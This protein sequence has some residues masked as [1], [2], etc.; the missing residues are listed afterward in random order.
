MGIM[1]KLRESKTIIFALEL[2]E[3]IE[4][5]IK[6]QEEKGWIIETV[7]HEDDKNFSFTRCTAKFYKLDRPEIPYL[8][9]TSPQE[10]IEAKLIAEKWKEICTELRKLTKEL[11]EAVKNIKNK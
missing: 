11:R 4:N 3:T 2:G 10:E 9:A 8:I 1:R 7:E 5:E 6:E